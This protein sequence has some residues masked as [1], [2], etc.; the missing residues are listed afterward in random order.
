MSRVPYESPRAR[1]SVDVWKTE[2]SEPEASAYENL[3]EARD[4]FDRLVAGGNHEWVQLN[5]WIGGTEN[6]GWRLLEEWPDDD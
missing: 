5:E 3:A 1:Y 6:E 2:T 4:D